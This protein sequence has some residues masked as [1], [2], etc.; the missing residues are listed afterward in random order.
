MVVAHNGD[1]WFGSHG[2][3]SLVRYS[4]TT[5]RFT[6]FLLKIGKNAPYELAFDGQGQLWFTSQGDTPSYI[7]KLTP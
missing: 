7:G 5:R 2:T 6:F 1:V 3:S 4:P